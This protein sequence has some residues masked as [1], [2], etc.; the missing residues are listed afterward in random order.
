MRFSPYLRFDLFSLAILLMVVVSCTKEDY[1]ENMELPKETAVMDASRY[2]V[3]LE[4][5]V[6]F[7]DKPQDDGITSSH[8]R[9]GEVFEVRAIKLEMINGEQVMWV[10]LENAG[11]LTSTSLKLY[12]TEEKAIVAARKLK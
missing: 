11:W 5:Y 9:A 1:I 7:R 12:P 2:A 4:P 6:T 10:C 3:V 8:A